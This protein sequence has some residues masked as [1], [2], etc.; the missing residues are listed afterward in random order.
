MLLIK[1]VGSHRLLQIGTWANSFLTD[2]KSPNLNLVVI[3]QPLFLASNFYKNK[4][5]THLF[6]LVTVEYMNFYEPI[7]SFTHKIS[8]TVKGLA[9]DGCIAF[10]LV[11]QY[12]FAK[13]IEHV[14]IYFKL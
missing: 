9:C 14:T 10:D 12:S 2:L 4:H 1:N 13:D 11:E 6:G 8:L 7:N 3:G 5:P